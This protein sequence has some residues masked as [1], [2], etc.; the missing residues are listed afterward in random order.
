M[1]ER[2]QYLEQL[3]DKKEN[4]MVKVITGIRRC[5]KSFL[6]FEIYRQYLRSVGVAED[7]I[8][9][10]ALD[11]DENAMYRD[12]V[13]LGE[14]VRGKMTDRNTMYY[15]FLDE[16]QK[17]STIQNPYVDDPEQKIGFVDVVLG[18]MKKPN[19]DVYVTGSNSKMLSSDIMTEFRGRGDEVL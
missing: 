4:G 15:I 8:I 13:R 6:L 7:Q 5:G 16:I 17:V 1:I 2:K 11:D 3:I 14:Y 10:L 12:P 19:A 9:E 18:L